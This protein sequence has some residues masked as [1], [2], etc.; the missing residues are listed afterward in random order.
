MPAAAQQDVCTCVV[1]MLE[2]P[3]TE[4]SLYDG[5]C[6]YTAVRQ[7]DVDYVIG[8][9]GYDLAN[10]EKEVRGGR[11]GAGHLPC[12][13]T[14]GNAMMRQTTNNTTTQQHNATQCHDASN[15]LPPPSHVGPP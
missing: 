11:G 12:H 4:Q 14:P 5:P 13:R 7:V 10:V 9:G 6:S 8:V 2:C 1:R 15:S 3:Y